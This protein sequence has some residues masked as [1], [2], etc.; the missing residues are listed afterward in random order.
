MIRGA[1]PFRGK[2]PHNQ[3]HMKKLML[4]LVALTATAVAAVYTYKCSR[5][6]LL[7]QY[8]QPKPGLKCP[9][10]GALMFQQ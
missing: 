1:N 3:T 4:V 6:G 2:N 10:D 8:S 5:C 9:R 7:Q